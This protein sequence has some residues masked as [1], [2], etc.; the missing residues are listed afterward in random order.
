MSCLVAQ[1][2]RLVALLAH[3]MQQA[4]AA[5]TATG[6]PE[7]DQG[8]AQAMT[9]RQAMT[10]SCLAAVAQGGDQGSASIIKHGG[11]RV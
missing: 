4:A 2:P 10:A 11:E 5:L 9:A 8:A 6:A 1:V 3:L 7:A